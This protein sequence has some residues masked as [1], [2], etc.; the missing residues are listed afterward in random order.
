MSASVSEEEDEDQGCGG[1]SK[2]AGARGR[3]TGS[4]QG[5]YDTNHRTKLNIAHLEE[6]LKA[7]L[8]LVGA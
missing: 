6:Q 5:P 3:L 4:K 8:E 1:P 7:K 2:R